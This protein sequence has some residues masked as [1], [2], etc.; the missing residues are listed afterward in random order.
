MSGLLW[1]IFIDTYVSQ[2]YT[3]LTMSN[4]ILGIS[5]GAITALVGLISAIICILNYGFDN[6]LSIIF[7][8]IFVI[9]LLIVG[10]VWSH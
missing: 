7:F 10:V 1:D 9:G 3:L 5:L 6:S 8:S 4:R 2:P